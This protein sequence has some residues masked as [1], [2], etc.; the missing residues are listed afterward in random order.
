MPKGRLLR[1]DDS[2]SDVLKAT[3]TKS[4]DKALFGALTDPDSGPLPTGALPHVKAATEAGK[5]A[6]FEALAEDGSK[7]TPKGKAKAKKG[8][9]N[10][11]PVKPKTELERG[12]PVIPSNVEILETDIA[13]IRI[14]T[15]MFQISSS[16]ES[17]R[18]KFSAN[19]ISTQ[20]M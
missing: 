4:L 2:T 7:V 3:A 20:R 17:K 1:Q 19:V 10:G 9:E 16:L 14:Q 18:L 15:C 5:K 11:E 8:S 6:V 13:R 12:S